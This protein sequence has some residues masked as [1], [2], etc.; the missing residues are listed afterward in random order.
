MNTMQI[1][2]EALMPP[3]LEAVP[4]ASAFNTKRKQALEG[5]EPACRHGQV[6]LDRVSADDHVK[7][8]EVEAGIIEAAG[9]FSQAVDALKNERARLM[10]TPVG[11]KPDLTDPSNYDTAEKKQ[12]WK[13]YNRALN[14]LNDNFANPTDGHRVAVNKA[15]N[16]LVAITK[17]GVK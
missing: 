1:L 6:A 12:A 10:Q 2:I 14:N 4:G 9:R 13:A 3:P 15:L 7:R 5:L 17:K 16:A 11:P 8:G